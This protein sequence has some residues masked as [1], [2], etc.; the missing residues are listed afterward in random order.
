ML[1]LYLLNIHDVMANIRL[2][3][4]D[5]HPPTYRRYTD[6]L[7]TAAAL[8]TT[9]HMFSSRAFLSLMAFPCSTTSNDM[10]KQ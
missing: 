3:N 2:A 6:Y 8:L 4:N 10:P 5:G 7:Q 1:V 9:G